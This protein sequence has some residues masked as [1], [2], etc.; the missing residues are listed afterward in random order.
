MGI[1]NNIARILYHA[2]T[3]DGAS[4]ENLITLGRQRNYLDGETLRDLALFSGRPD[5]DLSICGDAYAER[6]MRDWLGA[7]NVVALDNSAYEG[8][9]LIHDL[10]QPLPR[11][12]EERFDAFLACD[13]E[14]IF[15]LPQAFLNVMKA[16]KIGGRVFAGA[17]LNNMV[18]HGFYQL[19]PEI[20]F[21]VFAPRY[22][23]E[24]ERALITQ[25]RFAGPER[26]TVYPWYSVRDPD[27]VHRRVTLM[28]DFA[29]V[30]TVQARKIGKTPDG[31]DPYPQQSD[32][33]E[34]W[35]AAAG[36]KRAAGGPPPGDRS[37]TRRG[38]TVVRA[39]LRLCPPSLEDALRGRYEKWRFHSLRN[40]TFYEPIELIPAAHRQRRKR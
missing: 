30:L 32:Y 22:G 25:H 40:R 2:R 18:G 20:F 34:K 36:E 7:Q 33:A 37:W 27:A 8:A 9:T 17:P 35:S 23:F 39:L 1:T 13:L 28:N 3:K 14:H 11:Q 31:F 29:S 4:F 19:S 38:K 10:N 24:V 21:R 15:N 12:Y 6:F 5:P 26:N 16:T